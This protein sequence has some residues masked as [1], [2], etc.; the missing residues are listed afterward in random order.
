MPA[1]CRRSIRSIRSQPQLEAQQPCC[2]K[3]AAVIHHDCRKGP[4]TL[5]LPPTTAPAYHLPGSSYMC[6][7]RVGA[8]AYT[9]VLEGLDCLDM[10]L[11]CLV[12]IWCIGQHAH[13]PTNVRAGNL[14]HTGPEGAIKGPITNPKPAATCW[15]T[16]A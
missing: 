6:P 4:V 8:R 2:V 1:P 5:V 7:T 10:D 13:V 14:Q 11:V 12:C 9:L 3:S 15:C 16:G